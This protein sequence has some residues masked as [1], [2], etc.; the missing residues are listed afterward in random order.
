MILWACVENSIKQV[1]CLLHFSTNTTSTKLRVYEKFIAVLYTPE[2]YTID[3]AALS[4]FQ[5]DD[6]NCHLCSLRNIRKKDSFVGSLFLIKSRS[7]K[8]SALIIQGVP[9][10]TWRLYPR[11][12]KT[13]KWAKTAL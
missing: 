11:E 7:V 12:N 9:C 10:E 4:A 6:V 13:T 3:P 2:F 1:Y 8:N 5:P